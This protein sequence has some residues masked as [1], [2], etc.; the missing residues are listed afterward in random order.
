[1][2]VA[3]VFFEDVI[4]A[5][6]GDSSTLKPM[7]EKDGFV[8]DPRTKTFQPAGSAPLPNY[9]TS[10]LPTARVARAWQALET[11]KPFEP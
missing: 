3:K 4:S 7:F 1:L 2:Y 11:E 6:L 10:W 9:S 8:G 5:R